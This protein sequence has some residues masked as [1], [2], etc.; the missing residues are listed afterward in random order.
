MADG[1][2]HGLL[3]WGEH[4]R[5]EGAR[6]QE[7]EELFTWFAGSVDPLFDG[8]PPGLT[9]RIV[10][11]SPALPG[12][13]ERRPR[14]RGGVSGVKHFLDGTRFDQSPQYR[15]VEVV[16]ES[17]TLCCYAIDGALLLATGALAV[18]L[19]PAP[20][21]MLLADVVENWLLW[22]A[23]EAGA[24]MAHGSGWIREGAVE[25]LVGPS[26]VG[27]TTE[28]FRRLAGGAEFF[29]NDRIALRLREGRL[30]ARNFPQPIN[31]G[32]GTIRELDVDLPTFDL[33]D[34]CKIRLMPT[35]VLERW[36]PR[37]DRW[38]PVRA[39]SSP[40]LRE[41]EENVYWEGDPDHPFWNGALRPRVLSERPKLVAAIEK[42]LII[43]V[44]GA[45]ASIANE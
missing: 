8:G 18:V 40:S 32:C 15:D 1:G 45:P 39:I 5:L 23:R 44:R 3:I 17:P 30:L 43:D 34:R 4:V 28:L 33:E 7:L 36:R 27:K 21:P 9:I 10:R 14:H 26:G 24:V 42:S 37:Y 29:S 35:E 19:A 11:G 41:L 38:Y 12:G 6:A 2:A 31:V 13:L 16:F 20:P 25:M 22:R